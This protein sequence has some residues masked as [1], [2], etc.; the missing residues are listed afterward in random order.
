[1]RASY[2]DDYVIPLPPRHSFPMPKFAHLRGILAGEGLVP[3]C[4]VMEPA[5]A[6]WADLRL[7][8]TE[9]YLAA[10]ATGG[11][12]RD[13]ERRMGLPWSP[14]L[15]RRSRLA[16]QGTINAAWAALEDG[17][18]ANLAG[19][20]HHAFPERGEGFCVLNDVAVAAR[21]MLRARRVARVL[22]IDL[23]VHQGNGTAHAFKDDDRVFT[24]SMHG[25]KNFPLR[26]ERSDLDVPLP[27]GM[28]DGEYLAVLEDHLESVFE[29]SRP[30][31]V[32]YVQGVD[33]AAGDKFGR[34]RL[35]R[36][37]IAARDQ[38]VLREVRARGV[39]AVLLLG[40]GYAS[41]PR[42]TADLHAIMHREAAALGMIE[43]S[44]VSGGPRPGGPSL[45]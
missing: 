14:A 6:S 33:V 31:L 12:S 20:T 36:S 44:A 18:A 35:T 13:E 32:F 26:K 38:R 40:G 10:L 28:T 43:R 45:T 24:F 3:P 30:D 34:L 25:E 22:V 2:H 16:V 29:R 41:T 4:R 8:H 37:G 15:V 7:V 1:M 42:E 9:G 21:A 5:E 39:A 17:L 27:D 19:G 11:L 23:D